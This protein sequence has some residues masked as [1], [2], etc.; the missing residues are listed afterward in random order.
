MYKEGISKRKS[1]KNQKIKREKPPASSTAVTAAEKRASRVSKQQ[2]SVYQKKTRVSPSGFLKS[3]KSNA[4]KQTRLPVPAGLHAH[5]Y[6]PRHT[7]WVRCCQNNWIPP[8]RSH[9]SY[10]QP[11]IPSHHFV[12]VNV[13]PPPL[14]STPKTARCTKRHS[15][16]HDRPHPHDTPETGTHNRQI[17]GQTL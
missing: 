9:N 4:A 14:P 12:F 6:K 15:A 2:D 17:K 16:A 13:Q 8:Q 5:T 3:I 1:L 11:T 10:A 7:R